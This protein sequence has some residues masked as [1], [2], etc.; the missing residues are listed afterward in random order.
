MAECAIAWTM[1]QKANGMKI[2]PET[3]VWGFEFLTRPL[4]PPRDHCRELEGLL[5]ELYKR[6]PFEKR[7]SD[8]ALLK[9]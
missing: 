5:Q 3:I 6:T 8:K 4:I 2:N 1:R 7:V 9:T